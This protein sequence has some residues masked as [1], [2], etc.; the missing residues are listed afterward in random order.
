[1]VQL[2][3]PILWTFI[4]VFIVSVEASK[5]AK[6]CSSNPS[7]NVRGCDRQG[8]GHYRAARGR[9]R[10]YGV[11]IRC[12]PGST[13][14]APFAGTIVRRSRPYPNNR[15][16]FNNGLLIRGTGNFNGFSAKIWYFTP[17]LHSGRISKGRALG[18]SRRLLYTGITQHLHLQLYKG[19]KIVDPTSYL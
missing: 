13:V 11:D 16:A 10:H 2:N 7:N 19:R 9:R 5:L 4:L 12:S 14:Y 1:M 17:S 3:R 8:C 15:N 18:T 6:L